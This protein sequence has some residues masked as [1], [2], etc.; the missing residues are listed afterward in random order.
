MLRITEQQKQLTASILAQGFF[1]DPMWK[2]ILPKSQ[3]L[4]IL[5]AMFEVFVDNGFKRG[6]VLLAPEEQGAIVWYPAQM[7]VFDNAFVDVEA[8]ISAIASRFGELKA[9]ERLEKIGQ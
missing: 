5:T 2:F 1:D 8:E 9:I 3:R 6:E 7:N 4:Q